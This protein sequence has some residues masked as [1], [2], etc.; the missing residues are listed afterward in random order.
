MKVVSAIINP[1]K[2]NAVR[3]ALNE[4]GTKGATATEVKGYGH[5]KGHTEMYRGA[6]VDVKFNPKVKL[7]VGVEDDMV[8]QVINAISKAAKTGNVGDGKIFVTPL[9]RVV[10]IR[11]DETGEAAL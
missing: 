4:I 9:E 7:E 3:D 8:D 10:R 11:T 1:M 5:Q 6:V 2:L